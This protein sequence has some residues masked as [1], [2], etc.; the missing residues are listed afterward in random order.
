MHMSD[1]EFNINNS[2]NFACLLVCL[3]TFSYE[4]SLSDVQKTNS[5]NQIERN[6][7]TTFTPHAL[8][9]LPLLEYFWTGWRR[10]RP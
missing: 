8:F 9:L 4:L 5:I 1:S 3:L 6:Y 10:L 2:F 7:D